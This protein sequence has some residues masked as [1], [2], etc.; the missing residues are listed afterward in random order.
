M[1]LIFISFYLTCF[2]LI[3]ICGYGPFTDQSLQ[4]MRSAPGCLTRRAEPW[5]DTLW[6]SLLLLT[7]GHLA[8]HI[9]ALAPSINRWASGFFMMRAYPWLKT[10]G[11]LSVCITNLLFLQSRGHI[12]R[13]LLEEAGGLYVVCAG[14]I[15][16]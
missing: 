16:C 3:S 8:R 9:V 1:F 10:H 5:P 14:L 2:S 7:G 11:I 6:L 15:S 13:S 4:E 12:P